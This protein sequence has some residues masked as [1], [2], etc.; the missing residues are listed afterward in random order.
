MKKIFTLLVAA[1]FGSLAIGQTVFQSDLSSWSGTGDPIDWFGSKTTI[2]SADVIQT[3][4]SANYGTDEAALI[5]QTTSHKRFTTVSTPVVGGTTYVIKMW[6]SGVGDLRTGFY[7]ETNLAYLNP[8]NAYNNITAGPQ[9]VITQSVTIPATCTD[10]QFILS[11]RNTDATGILLDSVYIGAGGVT[12]PPPPAGLTTIYDIQF[13]TNPNGNSPEENNIVTT[14][15]VVTAYVSNTANFGAGSFFLQDGDGAWNGL[16]IY[17]QDTLKTPSVGDSIKVTGTISE[18]NLGSAAEAVTELTSIT[19]I[20]LLQSGGTLPNSTIISTA[21]AN[22]EDYEGV[23]IKV[24]GANATAV[25]STLGFGLWEMND[26]SGALKGD[27]DMYAYHLQAIQG[28]KYDVTGIGHYSFDDYK[29][30]P[31]KTSDVSLFTGVDELSGVTI[32]VYPNPVRDAINFK[33]DIAGYN[34]SI[35]DVTGKSVKTA[36]SLNNKLSVEVSNLNNGIYF[37]S[38]SDFDGNLI[39]TNKFIVAK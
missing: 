9:T 27:D 8:Y 35:V 15:G 30:L 24:V 2:A 11:L 14:K 28:T 3:T 36:S 13:T 5:N 23:L 38:I 4:G 18:F 33:L 1:S 17:N 19:D 6:V 20:T 26:G 21:D 39:S 37:Y 16:Y 10:A 31:R 29:I 12:P 34:V 7:D 32:T 25:G 22:S